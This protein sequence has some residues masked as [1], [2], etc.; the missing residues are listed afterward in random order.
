MAESAWHEF[1]RPDKADSAESKEIKRLTAIITRHLSS[2]EKYWERAEE[3]DTENWLEA[4]L[5]DLIKRINR[6]AKFW[7]TELMKQNIVV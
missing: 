5:Y 4:K 6:Y 1:V 7:E 3:V 2:A